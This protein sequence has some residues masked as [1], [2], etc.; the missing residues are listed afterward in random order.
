M[1]ISIDK[2]HATLFA[3][4]IIISI[5]AFTCL[6]LIHS[7]IS[8]NQLKLVNFIVPVIAAIIVGVL[9]ARNKILQSQLTTLANT[10]KLTKACNRQYFD[11]R[12]NEEVLSAK[13]YKQVFSIVFFDLDHFKKV[14]DQHG[15][16]A[17]DQ[18]LIEFASI[19]KNLNRDTDLFARYGGEEFILLTKMANKKTANKIYQRIQFAVREHIFGEVGHITFSAGIAE[20]N[21]E[22]DNIESLIKRAD[23][24]L[25]KAKDNGR[26]QAVI[27]D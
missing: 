16:S 21:Y 2:Q 7:Y 8:Y 6:T 5:A 27:A 4:Y 18:T 9:L 22:T 24:A 20:F 14:N 19:I 1:Y 11:L 17:G 12:L 13:R 15:H 26:D 3:I 23:K 10:D 25:Y